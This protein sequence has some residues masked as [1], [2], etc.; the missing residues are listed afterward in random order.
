MKI[1]EVKLPRGERA[2]LTYHIGGEVQYVIATNLLD[3][4]WYWRYNI[5]DGKLVKQKQKA[6]NPKELEG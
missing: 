1:S 3:T 4:T 5:E 6:H 2:V